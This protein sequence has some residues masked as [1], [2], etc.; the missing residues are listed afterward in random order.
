MMCYP[1]GGGAD[2]TGRKKPSK[3]LRSPDDLI[4]GVV[5]YSLRKQG[6]SVGF[7]VYINGDERGN[8]LSVRSRLSRPTYLPGETIHG[9]VVLTSYGA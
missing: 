7:M 3:R 8:R 6:I 1:V 2:T 4:R 9:L 5:A